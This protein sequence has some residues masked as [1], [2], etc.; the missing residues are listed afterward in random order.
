M[1]IL[2][3]LF[4][5]LFGASSFAQI[6]FYKLYSGAGFDK[7]EGIVQLADSSYMITGSSSSWG[8]NQQAFLMKVDSLGNYKWSQSYGGPETDQGKR[9][10]HIPG[11]G[12]LVAG[13]SN[14]FGDGDYDA[15]LFKTDEAGN[16]IWTKNYTKANAWEKINDAVLTADSGVVMVGEYLPL[17]NSN[18]DMYIIRTNKMGDTLWTK[19]W[20]NDGEDKVNAVVRVNDHFIIAGQFYVQD[21]S[22]VKGFLC[23]MDG[24]GNILWTDTITDKPGDYILEDVSLGQNKLYV[25][26]YNK[27]ASRNDIYFGV[28]GLNGQMMSQY[29]IVASDRTQLGRQL[30]YIPMRNKVAVAY[31]T[32]NSSTFQDDYDLINAYFDQGTIDWL[33]QFNSINKLGLDDQGQIIPTSDGGFISVGYG[34]SSSQASTTTDGGCHIFLN[35]VGP[36]DVFPST[37]SSFVLNQLVEI[38][39]N[40]TFNGVVFPNPVSDELHIH[41]NK[42]GVFDFLLMSLEG[43][44]IQEGTLQQF[45]SISTAELKAGIYLLR[46]GNAVVRFVKN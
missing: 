25:T 44:V 7:G 43:N 12:F 35:K 39:E 11:D 27:L 13:M 34:V 42:Q 15:F 36:N 14:S 40:E 28:F 45:D 31:Q 17:T 46:T 18:A 38:K 22:Q 9:I 33:G 24:D 6:S 32:I 30:E 16:L 21:S 8:E 20:G 10:M 5:C 26:G 29:T 4:S 41:F 37:T 1:R 23:E 3:L 19:R 2:I